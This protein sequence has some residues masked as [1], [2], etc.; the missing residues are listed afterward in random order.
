MT[1]EV[2]WIAMLIFGLIIVIIEA[3]A[4]EKLMFSK[5]DNAVPIMV[6]VLLVIAIFGEYGIFI[7]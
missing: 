3:V 1:N 5:N 7:L 2:K 6:A 4:Y